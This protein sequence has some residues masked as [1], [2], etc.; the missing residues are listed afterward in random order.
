MPERNELPKLTMCKRCGY[1]ACI[2]QFR[3]DHKPGLQETHG[4]PRLETTPLRTTPAVRV[5]DLSPM[6]VRTREERAMTMLEILVGVRELLAVERRW[7][8]RAYARNKA[9]HVLANALDPTACRWCLVGAY[10]KV[11]GRNVGRDS[12]E[13]GAA[14]Q[15]AAFEKCLGITGGLVNWQDQPGRKHREVRAVLDRAI[16]RERSAA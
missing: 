8:Q 10:E 2:C 16:E 9:G 4:V 15:R 14:I 5:R 13:V 7:T 11:A 3:R 6:H 12:T 1:V